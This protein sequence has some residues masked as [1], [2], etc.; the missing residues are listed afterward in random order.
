MNPPNMCLSV[1]KNSE[2][3]LFNIW[4]LTNCTEDSECREGYEGK[5]CNNCSSFYYPIN[6]KTIVNTTNGEGVDCQSNYRE[7]VSLFFLDAIYSSTPF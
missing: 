3:D 4:G 2:G 6:G 1:C 5:D 7:Q